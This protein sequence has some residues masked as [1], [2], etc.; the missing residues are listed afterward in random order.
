MQADDTPTQPAA[1]E[2]SIEL[3]LPL[4]RSAPAEVGSLHV[5]FVQYPGCQQL[6]VWLPP[7]GQ[8]GLG[9]DDDY[10][11]LRVTAADGQVIEQAPVAQRLNGSVQLLFDTLHWPPGAMTLEI[12]HHAGWQH[13]LTLNKHQ[14][15]VPATVER[16]SPPPP[17]IPPE[18]PRSE[19]IRYRDGFGRL[20][21]EPDLE[22]RAQIQAQLLA[23][24]RTRLVY[25]GY[26]R[27]GNYTYIEGD[28]RIVFS[29]EM[30]GGNC[31]S[32]VDLPRPQHWEAATGTPLARRADI[33]RFV[34]EEALRHVGGRRYELRDDSVALF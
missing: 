10:G 34:A 13:V 17:V 23:T 8:R 15:S 27:A 25:S 33:V 3:G 28:L 20:L 24:F 2:G 26:V 5:R 1:H 16:V 30:G 6:Q 11:D 9:G 18:P 7:R 31:L 19:P 22:L 32:V 12:A 21:P 14:E 4:N 29:Q